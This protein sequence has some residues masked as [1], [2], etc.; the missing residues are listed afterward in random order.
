MASITIEIPLTNDFKKE[1]IDTIMETINKVNN[2]ENIN[3][4]DSEKRK[5]KNLSLDQINVN[6]SHKSKLKTMWVFDLEDKYPVLLDIDDELDYDKNK[7]KLYY[8]I[9]SNGDWELTENNKDLNKETFESIA[10]ENLLKDFE[11]AAFY[12]TLS[13]SNEN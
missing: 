3:L 12:G 10:L 7:D 8:K 4:S 2:K 11:T 9:K 6:V 5:I 1:A 13:Y